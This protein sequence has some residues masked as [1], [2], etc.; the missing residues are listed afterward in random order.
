MSNLSL[1]NPLELAADFVHW[2]VTKCL[3]ERLVEIVCPTFAYH[4]FL[5]HEELDSAV[6]SDFKQ[7]S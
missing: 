7:L 2:Q 6:A 5:H 1:Q 3:V 4:L